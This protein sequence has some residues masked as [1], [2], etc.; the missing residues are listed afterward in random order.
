MKFRPITAI[1]M[2]LVLTAVGCSSSSEDPESVLRA[3]EAARNSG[4]TD[5]VMALYAEDAVVE[6]HPLD[7]T[8]PAT[9]VLEIRGYE[10]QVPSI[11]GST[12]G[13]EY[14]ELEVSGNTVTFNHAFVNDDGTCFGGTGNQVTVDDDK[15][16]L[17]VWG[18]EDP[19][20]C[21]TEVAAQTVTTEA[22]TETTTVLSEANLATAEAVVAAIFEPDEEAFD[23]FPWFNQQGRSEEEAVTIALFGQALH[24]EVL[25]TSC[26]LADPQLVQCQAHVTDDLAD[27][28]GSGVVTETYEF[29]FNDS[30]EITGLVSETQDGG[31]GET[32]T[33]WAWNIA[34]PGICDS[35]A[36]CAMALLDVVDEYNETYPGATVASYVAAYNSGDI[37]GVM[38]VYTEDS[39]LY[40]YPSTSEAAGLKAILALTTQDLAAAASTDAYSISNVEVDGDTVT[41]DQLWVNK[42]G[43]NWCMEGQSAVIKDGKIL[44]WTWP[45]GNSPCP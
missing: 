14:T 32:F 30:G 18:V 27:A 43:Q 37:D 26:H 11:Q 44:T 40:G 34:Y 2:A 22:A 20:Q 10:G 15:I 45:S 36:Q 25:D 24:V 28:L 17:F 35:P 6:N 23:G 1:V 33:N 12:G 8:S 7:T 4:E 41:W 13:T 5:A 29:T 31:V 21:T 38:A 39:V 19:T 9:G 16:T 3:Y 42:E